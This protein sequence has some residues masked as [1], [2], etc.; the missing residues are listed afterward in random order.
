MPSQD[1]GHDTAD[2]AAERADG[3]LVAW[4]SLRGRYSATVRAQVDEVM[5]HGGVTL[6][7]LVAMTLAEHQ[8]VL[9]RRA[10]TKAEADARDL[11]RLGAT[12]RRQ[13]HALV[14]EAGGG[15]DPD[16]P[17]SIPASVLRLMESVMPRHDVDLLA[18]DMDEDAGVDGAP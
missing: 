2:I 8:T 10:E 3:A 11:T 14:S 16:A 6:A 15:V 7:D 5:G 9:E 17:V 18:E 12:L 4:E 13:L 1:T